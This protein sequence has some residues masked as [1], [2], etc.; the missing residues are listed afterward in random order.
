MKKHH[1]SVLVLV[2]LL[3]SIANAQ[4]DDTKLLEKLNQTASK[5]VAFLME[6]G[7]DD[8]DGSY[9]KQL[10]PA[11]TAL[12]VSAL[13]RNGVPVGNQKIQQ[14]LAFLE[15]MARPD[16]GIYAKESNLKNYETSVS[17]IAFKQC[18]I[19][20]KYDELL[21]RAS[22]F[23]KGIQWDEGEGHTEASNHH[24]GQGYGSHERPDLSNTCLLYT[25]PSP[26]D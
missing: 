12:C 15:T 14:S 4:T 22:S 26:R 11:V 19:D 17:L 5:G 1:A 3:T 25:S 23:L 13:V 18:N 9:S 7:R 21:D 10:S 8:A 6:K 2:A 24:G 16:G 20:G